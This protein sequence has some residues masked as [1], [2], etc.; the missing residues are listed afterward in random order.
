MEGRVEPASLTLK[1][2]TC[3]VLQCHGDCDPI[4]FYKFGQLSSSVLKSFMKNSHFQ[5]Y[6]GLGHSSCDAELS[7]MKVGRSNS[8][9]PPEERLIVFIVFC[10]AEIHRRSCSSPVKRLKPAPRCG[11]TKRSKCCNSL[12][13]V[14]KQ[15]KNRT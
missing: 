9:I 8:L 3:Q 12:T 1:Y 13:F 7:D 15:T 6:Q 14:R 5:T 11:S 2:S 4:V 10:F